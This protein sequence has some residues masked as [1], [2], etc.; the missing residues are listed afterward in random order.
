MILLHNSNE[1]HQNKSMFPSSVYEFLV[2]Q[3]SF[4]EDED[5][6]MNVYGS[7][8]FCCTTGTIG[9]ISSLDEL[10]KMEILDETASSDNIRVFTCMDGSLPLDV[11]LSLPVEHEESALLADY[12]KLS[13]EEKES[14][15]LIMSNYLR[16]YK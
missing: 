5:P 6:Q 7:M 11:V 8:D 15:R 9:I 13:V 2:R 4:L 3:F 1:L 10:K 14:I 16:K 12:R